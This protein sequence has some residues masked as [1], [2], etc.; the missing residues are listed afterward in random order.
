MAPAAG[1]LI[2]P[3]NGAIDRGEVLVRAIEATVAGDRAVLGMLYTEGVEGWSPAMSVS[4]AAELAVELGIRDR[5]FS[6][7]DLEVTPLEVVW[8]PGVCRVGGDGD[9]L[10]AAGGRRRGDRGHRASV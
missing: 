8:R 10:R 5:A 7:I 9:P 1:A 4:S 3:R 6:D 2:R